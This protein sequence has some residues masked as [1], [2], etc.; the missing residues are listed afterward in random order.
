M[1]THQGPCVAHTLVN[2]P[3]FQGL[4]LGQDPSVGI[5]RSALE[6]PGSQTRGDW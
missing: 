4:V 1:I 6:P 3:A 5:V 2:I